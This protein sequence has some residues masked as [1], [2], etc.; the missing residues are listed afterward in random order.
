MTPPFDPHRNQLWSVTLFSQNG[1]LIIWKLAQS[2]DHCYVHNPTVIVN[3]IL[4][5]FLAFVLVHTFFGRNLKPPLRT[6][7]TVIG[8]TRELRIGLG[9]LGPDSVWAISFSL[10]GP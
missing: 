4:T 6:H 8:L 2:L 1:Y 9:S 7:I 3:V 5:L 10:P